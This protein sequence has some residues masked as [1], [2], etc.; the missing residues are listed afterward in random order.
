[1][2]KSGEMS[3]NSNIDKEKQQQATNIRPEPSGT[4]ADKAIVTSA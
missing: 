1:M 3:S 2:N 4:E